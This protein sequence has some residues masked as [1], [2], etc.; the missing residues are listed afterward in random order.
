[1]T[2]R[3]KINKD[4]E[5]ESPLYEVF[6]KD[7]YVNI[8]GDTVV[9]GQRLQNAPLILSNDEAKQL[10][11]DIKNMYLRKEMGDSITFFEKFWITIMI[12]GWY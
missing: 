11:K 7:F 6:G 5:M 3:E 9:T 8:F 12:K 4:F 10:V 2:E 1:M